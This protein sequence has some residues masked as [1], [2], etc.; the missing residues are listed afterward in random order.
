M[1][2][3]GLEKSIPGCT[4]LFR[5]GFRSSPVFC[6]RNGGGSDYANCS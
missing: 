4:L 2:E 5:V 1:S 3:Q 6:G